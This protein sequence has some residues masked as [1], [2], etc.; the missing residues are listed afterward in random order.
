MDQPTDAR[1]LPQ[2]LALGELS[3]GALPT[4]GGYNV[5]YLRPSGVPGAI[6]EDENRAPLIAF[7]Q[8]GLGR[9]AVYTG[10]VGGRYGGE[11]VAWEGFAPLFVT[12]ARWLGGQEEP[13][14]L[15]ATL[16]RE[17]RSGRITVDVDPDAATPPDT[18]GLTAVLSLPGGGRR[19]LPL[20]PVTADRY[21]A[22]FPLEREGIVL[23]AVRVDDERSLRLPPIALPYSPE[24]EP[25]GDAQRGERLLG[26]I[27][28]ETGGALSPPASDL[29]R[30]PRQG[31]ALRPVARELALLALI[32][33]LLEI[34]TRRLQ[35]AAFLPSGSALRALLQRRIGSRRR[36]AAAAATDATA[37]VPAPAT[38]S[39][40][41]E[42]VPTPGRSASPSTA[43]KPAS[44]SLAEAMARARRDADR[45]L[46]R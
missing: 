25:R 5:T 3:A 23:G 36:T 10:Q 1:L 28:R 24:F 21:A 6:T 18:S 32:L 37:P 40:A 29:F 26:R 27:A 19:E 14:A 35:L 8:R 2:L 30:G 20:E 46:R 22:R 43:C 41:Q 4:L 31:R 16:Q 42:G 9:A 15:F 45:E 39:A 17:G 34:A 33:W 44:T 7:H 11:L 12:L 13:E 38:G